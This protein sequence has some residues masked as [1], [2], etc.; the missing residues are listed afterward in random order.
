MTADEIWAEIERRGLVET[1]GKTLPR[2][3]TPK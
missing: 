3:S 2:R 1:T